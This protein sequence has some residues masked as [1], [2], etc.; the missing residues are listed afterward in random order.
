MFKA[1][2]VT[3]YHPSSFQKRTCLAIDTTHASD[4]IGLPFSA[5]TY[6]TP[7]QT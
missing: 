4:S 5:I 7:T 2:G 6:G 1:K 3:Y